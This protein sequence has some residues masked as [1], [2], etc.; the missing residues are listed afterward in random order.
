MECRQR[1]GEIPS[2]KNVVAGETSRSQAQGNYRENNKEAPVMG[3][4]WKIET[5]G[6]C[7]PRAQKKPR[8]IIPN[9]KLE[10]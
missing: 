1:R 10:E 5:G 7:L 4:L 2:Y 6:R 3:N 9:N 8:Y